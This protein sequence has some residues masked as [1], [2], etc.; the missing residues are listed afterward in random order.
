MSASIAEIMQAAEWYTEAQSIAR[1]MATRY[2]ETLDSVACVIAAFSPRT[3]WSQNL[4]NA[5]RFLA[6]EN[7]GALTNNISMAGKGLHDG[8]AALKGRKTNS[9]AHNIAGYLDYVTV[10]VWMIRAAGY[11]RNDANKGM[12]DLISSVVTD[13]A[14]DAGIAPAQMQALIWIRIRGSHV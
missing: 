11:D 10:D 13:L 3:K 14:N 6:G 12:Y 4:L 2:N 9:F 5:E 8:F 1:E 7:V